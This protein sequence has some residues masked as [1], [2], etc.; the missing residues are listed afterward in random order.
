MNLL[1]NNM[2]INDNLQSPLLTISLGFPF[3]ILYHSK[4][5]LSNN[6]MTDVYLFNLFLTTAGALSAKDCDMSEI[7][8]DQ[9]IT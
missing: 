3:E 8:L 9:F 5:L 4:N 6:W 1:L 2:G 7:K